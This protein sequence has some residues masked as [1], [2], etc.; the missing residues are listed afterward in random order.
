[1]AFSSIINHQDPDVGSSATVL[2]G[3]Y[4]RSARIITSQETWRLIVHS[5]L[6]AQ[7]VSSTDNYPKGFTVPTG[8]VLLPVPSPFCHFVGA[9]MLYDRDTRVLF[10]GDLFGSLT[11]QGAKGLVADESDWVGMRAFHQL[12]MPSN[13]ALRRA[14]AAIRALDPFPE[15]IAPQHGRIL[16][17]PMLQE[18]LNRIEVLEVGLDNLDDRLNESSTIKGWNGVLERITASLISLVGEEALKPILQDRAL[19]SDIS[20]KGARIEVLHLGKSTVE[21]IIFLATLGLDPTVANI[22]R[23]EAIQAAEEYDLPVPRVALEEVE[24]DVDSDGALTDSSNL[25]AEFGDDFELGAPQ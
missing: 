3:R 8:Q 20:V 22:V 4:A 13:V 6:P 24:V 21:R 10:T 16:S 12:Y 18:F 2:S 25:T 19:Q 7:R 11:P 5:N 9:V 17:G 15:V 14:V 1:M 23:F